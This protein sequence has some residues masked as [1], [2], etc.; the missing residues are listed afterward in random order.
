[1]VL[2]ALLK[3]AMPAA[4]T[5]S[6][7]VGLVV[8]AAGA[9]PAVLV[10]SVAAPRTAVRSRRNVAAV[11]GVVAPAAVVAPIVPQRRSRGYT[12]AIASVA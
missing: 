12:A 1:M 8:P 9:A 5:P 2:G 10:A 6:V 11:I 7:G 3:A 4:G